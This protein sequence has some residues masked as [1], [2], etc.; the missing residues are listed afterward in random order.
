VQLFV[1]Q[2][3]Q[4]LE[5]PKISLSPAIR[6]DTNLEIAVVGTR[7]SE[8]RISQPSTPGLATTP[9]ITQLRHIHDVTI[10][11]ARR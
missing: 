11:P 5:N 7:F 2:I 3:P 10:L 1:V 8:I 9:T 6:D 4:D